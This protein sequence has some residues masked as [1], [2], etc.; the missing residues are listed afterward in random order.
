MGFICNH[1]KGKYPAFIVKYSPLIVIFEFK[2]NNEEN[3]GS[4]PIFEIKCKY[5]AKSGIST[6]SLAYKY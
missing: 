3:I 2:P 6:K 5:P 1:L 4:Y